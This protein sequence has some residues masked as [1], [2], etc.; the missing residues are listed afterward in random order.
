MRRWMREGRLTALLTIIAVLGCEGT[1]TMGEERVDAG[2]PAP[3]PTPCGPDGAPP[4][5]AG[6]LPADAG[7]SPTDAGTTEP[8][9]TDTC[10]A[11]SGRTIVV[12]LERGR[13]DGDGS[14]ATPF[15]T[16]TAAL[17]TAMAGDTI[18]I[19]RGVY[20]EMLTLP[21]D[22][23]PG[24]PIALCAAAGH[25][26]HVRGSDEVDGFRRDS[27]DV[28]VREGWTVNSQQVFMDGEPLAQIGANSGWHAVRYDGRAVL[29]SDGAGRADMREGS[30]YYDPGRTRLY[31]WLPGGADPAAHRVEA[32][33]RDHVIP[34]NTRSH[35]EL[36]GLRFAHSN[37]TRRNVQHGMVNITGT[38]WVVR[39]CSFTHGDFSGAHVAGEHHR[40][41]GNTF[42]HNGCMG[43]SF[44]GSLERCRWSY[45][46]DRPPQDIL[47]ESNQTNYNNYRRFWSGWAGGGI[48]MVPAAK[49]VTI[50]FHR[51]I[52]NDGPGIW[53]DGRC[54]DVRILSSYVADNRRTGIFYEISETGLIANN[55]VVRNGTQGIYV[56]SSSN[57]RVYHNTVV[58]NWAGIVVH[59]GIRSEHPE[60][61]H[62]RLVGNVVRGSM[63]ADLVLYVGDPRAFDNTT[64]LDVLVGR[65]AISVTRGSGYDVSYRDLD[66]Y[67]R[68]TGQGAR[69]FTT[70]DPGWMDPGADDYRLRAGSMLVDRGETLE[71]LG[72]LDASGAARVVDGDGDGEAL[73]DLG[74]YEHAR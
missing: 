12:S 45:C 36:H 25:E 32:S 42:D 39:G 16:I 1:L 60:L 58:D 15:R 47:I 62:N 28:W 13:D 31:V 2:A 65:V 33:V 22:G 6:E 53:C 55:V 70:S 10:P 30:F 34:Y 11:P 51:A 72:T 3:C 41:V 9:P 8:P 56:A 74:A 68:A 29:P 63:N 4:R 27:G 17:S 14:S 71:G 26:V 35:I 18:R 48:K 57:T 38:H 5:D 52:G 49:D 24:R 54:H 37:L 19:E 50:R 46:D 73:P 43:I 64:D 59:G 66:A 61:A 40:I 7:A 67:R 44:N 23:A 21:R 20:R 69:S